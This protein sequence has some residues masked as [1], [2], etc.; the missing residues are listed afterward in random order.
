MNRLTTAALAAALL[1]LPTAAHADWSFTRWGMSPDQVIKAAKGK[2]QPMAGGP[3]DR[4]MDM[5]PRAT[6]GPFSFE[7]RAYM[8]NFYFDLDGGRGLRVVRL[9]LLDQGQCDALG[10]ELEKRYGA[11]KNQY[12]GE[13]TDPAT[14]DGVFLSKSYKVMPGM[15]CYVS[16]TRLGA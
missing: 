8:A 13:W 11:S 12:H 14:G 9:N 15:A 5:D 1:T 6:G 10:A 3:G 16:Y 4:V 2:A 7:G